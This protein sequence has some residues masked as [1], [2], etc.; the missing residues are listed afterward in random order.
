MRANFVLGMGRTIKKDGSPVTKTDLAINS[1]VINEVKKHFPKHGV[2]GEEESHP[3]EGA[4]YVWVCDPVDGT[5]PF[6][7]GVPTCM[8]SLALTHHGEPILGVAYDAFTNRLFFAEKGKGAFL[9]GKKIRVSKLKE[10]KGSYIA[11]EIWANMKYPLPGLE[12]DFVFKERGQMFDTNSAVYNS[13]LIAAGQIEG[14]IFAHHTAHDIA[15]V[16]VIVEEAGGEVTDLFGKGQRYDMSIKGAI[17]SNGT[18]HRKLI[19]LVKKHLK[20]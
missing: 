8:F 13:C 1:M 7:R 2:L 12:D 3:I 10:L 14:Y 5:I 20:V 17:I 18:I 6:L 19:S 11:N 9:N 16:K 4:E 15:A